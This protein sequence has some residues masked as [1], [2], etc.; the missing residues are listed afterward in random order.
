MNRFSKK[1]DKIRIFTKISPVGDELLH[2][3]GRTD[4]TKLIDV[5]CNYVNEPKTREPNSKL[6]E[7][8][9]TSDLTR[10][11]KYIFN[12]SKVFTTPK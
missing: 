11:Y 2:A 5:F 10:C 8:S 1:K 3:G 6:E 12:R 4:V 7:L 9:E